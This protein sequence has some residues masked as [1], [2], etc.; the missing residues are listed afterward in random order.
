MLVK[1]H[2]PCFLPDFRCLRWPDVFELVNESLIR[3][4]CYCVSLQILDLL[5]AV[6]YYATTV[7]TSTDI[8][9]LGIEFLWFN[10]SPSTFTCCSLVSIVPWPKPVFLP[11]IKDALIWLD[12]H[13]SCF[14]MRGVTVHTVL[15]RFSEYFEQGL[16]EEFFLFFIS[17]SWT[18]QNNVH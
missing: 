3:S 16:N 11:S 9:S 4:L 13:N 14:R 10:H 8:W 6:F 18:M 5:V 2:S 12:L 17:E 15:I 7:C 1:H